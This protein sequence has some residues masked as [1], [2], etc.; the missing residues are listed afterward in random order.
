MGTFINL[1]GQKFNNL[2]VV[3]RVEDGY[4]GGIK[5]IKSNAKDGNIYPNG[6]IYRLEYQS[7]KSII[8]LI[9][10]M[11]ESSF[12]LTR[13]TEKLDEIMAHLEKSDERKWAARKKGEEIQKQ[14][15]STDLIN[16]K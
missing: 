1:T 7:K 8:P 13:K 9:E 4:Q 5:W 3:E 15:K 12:G 11:K 6:N 16:E 14:L 10:L 2:L